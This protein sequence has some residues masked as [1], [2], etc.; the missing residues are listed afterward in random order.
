MDGERLPGGWTLDEALANHPDLIGANLVWRA[1]EP[2]SATWDHAHCAFCWAQ[3]GQ[4]GDALD[5]AYTDDVAEAED[6]A[7]IPF[8]DGVL[9]GA[10]AGART[11]VCGGCAEAYRVGFGWRTSPRPPDTPAG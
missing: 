10:P 3:I 2:P 4:G 7:T 8:G 6:A 5:A 11:W 9:V 1:Y